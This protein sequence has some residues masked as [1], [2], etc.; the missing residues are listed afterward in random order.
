MSL[1]ATMVILGSP[2]AGC[3]TPVMAEGGL[4]V[5]P[6]SVDM[7]RVDTTRHEPTFSGLTLSNAGLLPAKLVG[8]EFSGEGSEWLDV[9]SL[10]DRQ[11]PP[12]QVLDLELRLGTL[13][14][15]VET[16]WYEVWATVEFDVSD[17]VGGGCA[18]SVSPVDGRPTFEVPITFTVVD[19]CD[20]DGDGGRGGLGGS[21]GAEGDSDG[22]AGLAGSGAPVIW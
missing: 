16:G 15:G 17:R 21:G 10:T 18:L 22:E 12:G 7:G 5:R 9:R 13:P 3:R 11:L 20:G 2:A 8:V 6:G 4:E 19:A 14:A 1:S